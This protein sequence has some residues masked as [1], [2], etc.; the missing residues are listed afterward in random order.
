MRRKQETTA[1]ARLPSRDLIA[2][3]AHRIY[4][5][6]G[7]QHGHDIDDW[8]QAEYELMQLP[9]RRLAEIDPP[10][11]RQRPLVGK[12]VITLVQA[13]LVAGSQGLS[14]LLR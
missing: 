4:L 11:N 5:E 10:R 7:G 8:L 13:A 2:A 12:S 3:R 14:D 9:I 6:R 1:V